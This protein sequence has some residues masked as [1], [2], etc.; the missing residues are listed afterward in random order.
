MPPDALRPSPVGGPAS[1]FV[2]SCPAPV[3]SATTVLEPIRRSEVVLAVNF[4][5]SKGAGLVA[6]AAIAQHFS[7]YRLRMGELWAAVDLAMEALAEASE[8]GSISATR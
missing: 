3:P 4:A 7:A 1:C 5:V 8:N 6:F 2:S